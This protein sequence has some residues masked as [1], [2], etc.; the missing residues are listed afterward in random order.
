MASLGR[1]AS[2][3]WEAMYRATTTIGRDLSAGKAWGGLSPSEYGVLYALTQAPTGIRISD[4]GKDV[5]LT[6]PG[7][8]RL[9]ARLVHKGFIQRLADPDDG[10]ATRLV[11]TDEGRAIQRR[12]GSIHAREITVSMAKNLSAE[13]LIHLRDLCA[14]I[15]QE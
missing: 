11:L 13:E 2:E 14:K 12:V 10:R 1:A 4:L 6:Q 5:L 7:L 9:A 15:L 8:T 3:A